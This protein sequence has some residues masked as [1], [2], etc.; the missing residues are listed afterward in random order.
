MTFLL[1]MCIMII[2]NLMSFIQEVEEQN[3]KNIDEIIISEEGKTILR[4]IRE[5]VTSAVPDSTVIFYGSRARG[6]PQEHSD[7]DVLILTEKVSPSIKDLIYDALFEIELEHDIIIGPLILARDEW[8]HK[9][10][11]TH[12]IHERIVEE[13]VLV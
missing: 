8:E 2:K 10:Y 11:K 1:N 5:S 7:W 3:M 4:R 6:N 9:R 13:G 12:P